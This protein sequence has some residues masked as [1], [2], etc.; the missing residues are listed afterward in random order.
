MAVSSRAGV[1][2]SKGFRSLAD[3]PEIF[4]FGGL[5]S[6]GRLSCQHSIGVEADKDK[7]IGR[8]RQPYRG[9]APHSFLG[10]RG[11]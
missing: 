7:V 9:Y 3:N 11:W 8:K 10:N 6:F 2:K 4:R 1:S 5:A